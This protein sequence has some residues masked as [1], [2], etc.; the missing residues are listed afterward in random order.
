MSN[1]KRYMQISLKH[2]A[3]SSGPGFAFSAV[4]FA[5]PEENNIYIVYSKRFET[6]AL[7]CEFGKLLTKSFID[8]LLL[9]GKLGIVCTEVLQ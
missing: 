5:R 7:T 6:S 4:R 2:S 8:A 1:L 3:S 9:G